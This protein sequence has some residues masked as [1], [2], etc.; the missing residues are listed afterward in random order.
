VLL[1]NEEKFNHCGPGGIQKS[2]NTN[3]EKGTLGFR[4]YKRFYE[5]DH[6]KLQ[7]RDGLK[8]T[9]NTGAGAISVG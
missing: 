3:G 4:G 2:L 5:Q 1:K 8:G 7:R 9:R 6:E